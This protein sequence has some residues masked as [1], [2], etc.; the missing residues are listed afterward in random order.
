MFSIPAGCDPQAAVGAPPIQSEEAFHT[1]LGCTAAS[2]IDFARF[3]LRITTRTLSPA[4]VGTEVVDDG[5]TVTFVSLGRDPCPGEPPPMPMSVPVA[6][7][8]PTG[9]TRD[10]AESWCKVSVSCH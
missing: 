5:K 6:F 3:E 8:L 10:T 9:A 4:G 2:G 1:R 7:L